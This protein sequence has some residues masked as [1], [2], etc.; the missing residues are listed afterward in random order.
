MKTT[1]TWLRDGI[2]QK[3]TLIKVQ[4]LSLKDTARGHILF[5]GEQKE[6]CVLTPAAAQAR[7]QIERSKALL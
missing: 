1:F 7:M 6:R 3:R 2:P 5:S 4:D